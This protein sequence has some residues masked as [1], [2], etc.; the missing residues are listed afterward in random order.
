VESQRRHYFRDELCGF[1]EKN[2]ESWLRKKLRGE[3]HWAVGIGRRGSIGVLSKLGAATSREAVWWDLR[4]ASLLTHLLAPFMAAL[5][6]RCGH[7][8]PVLSS[9]FFF[10]SESQRSQSG[11]LPCF[12]TWCGRSA[13]LECRSENVLHAA[14]WTGNT[15]RK[16]DAKNRHLICAPSHTFVGLNFRNY[17]MYRQ[18]EKLAKQQYLLH[19][20]PQ[21][22]TSAH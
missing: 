2:I 19:T 4:L 22:R 11:C 17:G 5:R 7:F 9:F 18:S 16:N 13:N 10:I 3:T 1:L 21:W 6:S 8:G 14:R 12:Y 20:S 15:G